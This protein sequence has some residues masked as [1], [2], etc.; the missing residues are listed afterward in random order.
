MPRHRPETRI[1]DLI[2]AATGVFLE[3][4]YRRAQIADIAAA[5]S[6][7][8]GTVYLYVE[9]KEALFDAVIQASTSPKIVGTLSIPMK[10]PA[11]GSTLSFIRN[12]LSKDARI[13]SLEAALAGPIPSNATTELREIARELY[14][15]AAQ[16]WLSLKLMERSAL[17][18]PE[19]AALWFG[20][21]RLRILQQLGKYLET[22][23]N[24]GAL[25]GAPDAPAAARLVLEMIAA[26]AVHCRQ[27]DPS[28]TRIEPA[29]AE[30][31]VLDAIAHA[32]SPS[33]KTRASKT[34]KGTDR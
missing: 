23:M 17:D 34:S 21:Y 19:L 3:K 32:Y 18:W 7:A 10:T 20:K 27:H 28:P 11:P 25:R 26:F 4:G 8:P 12:T 1:E 22:R 30:V 33:T 14:S 2:E 9:S 24:C 15:K 29:I 6:V 16:S 5:M 31:T 13:A